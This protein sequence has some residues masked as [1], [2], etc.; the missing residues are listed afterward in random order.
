MVSQP[1]A[2][3]LHVCTDLAKKADS[4]PANPA[5]I[6]NTLKT[7]FIESLITK[8]PKFRLTV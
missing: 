1:R 5:L 4:D 2:K 6:E 3:A 7:A 8:R